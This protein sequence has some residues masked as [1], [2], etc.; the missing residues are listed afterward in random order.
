MLD[1]KIVAEI[2]FPRLVCEKWANQETLFLN[3]VFRIVVSFGKTLKRS[4]TSS[5]RIHSITVP[6]FFQVSTAAQK[7][8]QNIR[9]T[10]FP[11]I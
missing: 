6:I 11:E 1:G 2:S 3:H 8:E 4:E 7:A 5:Y 9:R 10:H